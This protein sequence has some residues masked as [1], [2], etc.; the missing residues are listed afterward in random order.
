[1]GLP[2]RLSGSWWA[3]TSHLGATD[4]VPFLCGQPLWYPKSV[5]FSSPGHGICL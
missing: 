3:L 4:L 2:Y 5:P 1:M